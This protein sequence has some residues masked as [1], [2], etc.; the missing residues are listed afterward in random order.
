MSQLTI[1]T[2][3]SAALTDAANIEPPPESP[4]G[5][6]PCTGSAKSGES[7]FFA[8]AGRSGAP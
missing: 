3:G 4:T 2:I 8:A 1:I 5:I 7:S 6:H